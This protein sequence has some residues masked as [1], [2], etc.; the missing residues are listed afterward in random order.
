ML[1]SAAKSLFALMPGH[2]RKLHQTH[3]QHHGLIEAL[4]PVRFGRT[5]IHDVDPGWNF[6]IGVV[7]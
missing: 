5:R 7:H 6:H 3:C 4:P 2:L 1:L